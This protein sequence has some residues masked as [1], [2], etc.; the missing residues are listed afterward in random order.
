M[1]LFPSFSSILSKCFGVKKLKKPR[2][3][4]PCEFARAI[5]KYR[6]MF[7]HYVAEAFY[8]PGPL[9]KKCSL[10]ALDPLKKSEDDQRGVFYPDWVEKLHHSPVLENTGKEISF[11]SVSMSEL[12]N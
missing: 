8:L 7:L 10:R 4:N 5:Y 3:L 9:S 12:Q 2:S 11:F 1:K 6:S